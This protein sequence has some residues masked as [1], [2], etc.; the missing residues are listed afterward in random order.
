VTISNDSLISESESEALASLDCKLRLIDDR[1]TAVVRGYQ[2]GLYLCG[3]G[4]LGKSYSVYRQLRHLECDFRTFN[5]RM[6][7]L[8]LFR[9][10]DKAPDAVHVLEDMERITSDRDAQG[11]L[12][13]ALWSQGDQDRVVTWTTSAGE[14]RPAASPFTSLRSA[15][16]RCAGICGGL[17]GRAGADTNTSWRLN[18]V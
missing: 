18:N 1:V 17:H 10:L 12:R 2:T 14:Q 8:G 13:S 4:G 11:V 6:T 9:A 15:T 7:A 5:S 3:A 16:Q